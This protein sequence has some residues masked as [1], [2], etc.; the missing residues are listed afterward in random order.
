ML[1]H[2]LCAIHLLTGT[3]DPHAST[4]ALLN[5]KKIGVNLVLTGRF[6]V[7]VAAEVLLESVFSF[8]HGAG[9]PSSFDVPILMAQKRFPHAV[10]M[11]WDKRP[12][13]CD[14]KFHPN[15]N[16]ANSAESG[17]G[18]FHKIH[19]QGLI[20]AT[21]LPKLIED[22]HS[23]SRATTTP[24]TTQSKKRSISSAYDYLR[25]KEGSQEKTSADLRNLPNAVPVL[26]LTSSMAPPAP[27]PVV[28]PM[29]LLTTAS[30]KYAAVEEESGN[31]G[32]S[33]GE[34]DSA[35][36]NGVTKEARGDGAGN[37]KTASVVSGMST[38]LTKR[39]LT[40]SGTTSDVTDTAA[41][42]ELRAEGW[43]KA[44]R[45]ETAPYFL[46]QLSVLTPRCVQMSYAHRAA[47]RT[48]SASGE[49]DGSVGVHTEEGE[50]LLQAEPLI[51]EVRWQGQQGNTN[52]TN[53]KNGEFV[54]VVTTTQ[55]ALRARV[56]LLPKVKS[57]NSHHD[58]DHEMEEHGVVLD[59]LNK[60]SAFVSSKLM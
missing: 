12:V 5:N 38:T 52:P 59:A 18:A 17:V 29:T 22:L 21:T 16:S 51:D 58:P 11:A 23:L 46:I 13:Q 41:S 33:E 1:H 8:V 48:G 25:Q 42:G 45:Q 35:D 60:Y 19:M 49:G 54:E 37:S 10:Q 27:A 50:F 47:R 34:G 20:T 57:A 6:S 9:R 2:R 30:V 32:D 36:E 39:K 7:S 31:E 4:S 40:N 43:L 44:R 14:H 28:N 15:T 24:C 3:I 55:P 53:S 56:L 26:P